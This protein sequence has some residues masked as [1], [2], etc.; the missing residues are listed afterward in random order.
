MQIVLHNNGF[1]YRLE[2]TEEKANFYVL[3]NEG[4]ETL[5]T[6]LHDHSMSRFDFNP[7]YYEYLDMFE[8]IEHL[9]ENIKE[10]IDKWAEIEVN[11]GLT[12]TDCEAYEKELLP[13]GY[14]FE[15]SLDALPYD[16][17]LIK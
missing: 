3:Q 7:D 14:T 4:G 10:I 2:L 8:Y 13:L 16:L 12:Y 6:Y 15:W 5:E 17:N 1:K 9:P 11:N